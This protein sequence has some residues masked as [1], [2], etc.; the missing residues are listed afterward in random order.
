MVGK[1]QVTVS[2]PPLGISAPPTAPATEVSVYNVE[3]TTGESARFGL[4]LAGNE[5][6]LEGDVDWSG[7][8]HEGFTIHVPAALPEAL[9]G[10]LG[11]LGGEK[12]LILQNR[13]VFNGRSGDG[14]FITTPTTCLGPAYAPTWTKGEPP[15][16]PSGQIYSTFLLRRARCSEEER[17]GYAVPAERRTVARVADPARH[18]AQ[19]MRLDPLRTVARGRPR[20]RPDRLPRRPPTSTSKC[21]T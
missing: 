4:E 18:L 17:V 16:G 2:L 13:L 11:L 14:T 12:G 10:L 15:N 5:V 19:R 3:P 20:H 8:Y 9:G 6:F 7:D 21:R 1:S